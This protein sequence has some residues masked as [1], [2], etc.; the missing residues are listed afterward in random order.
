MTGNTIERSARALNYMAR[1]PWDGAKWIADRLYGK[2]PIEEG[3]PWVAWPCIRFLSAWVK[4]GFKVFEWG[5]GGSTLFFLDAGCHVTTIESSKAWAEKIL[6]KVE[7]RPDAESRLSLR[8]IEAD[9]GR[10]AEI[11]N[12]VLSVLDGQP[13]DLI[14]VDGLEE[15][16]LSR[17][18]CAKI[19][20][21]ALRRGG[22]IALDDAWRPEYRSV[23]H[24]LSPLRRQSFRGFGPARLG[25]TQTDLYFS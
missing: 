14:L 2:S 15:E 4:P 19:A 3:L 17:V 6:A 12:Y 8:L 5:G 13:W 20:P 21:T 10:P 16:Y 22:A 11:E 23:P 24:L 18:E 9:P 7:S 1:N 25:V